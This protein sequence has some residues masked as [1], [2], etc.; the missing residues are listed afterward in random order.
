[1]SILT[2]YIHIYKCAVCGWPSEI[3]KYIP[4]TWKAPILI[5]YFNSI[6]DIVNDIAD[7]FC[8][9]CSSFPKNAF[10]FNTT[11]CEW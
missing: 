8:V 1:M 5:L 2:L 6:L 7:N 9:I 4:F 11:V 10:K 3:E